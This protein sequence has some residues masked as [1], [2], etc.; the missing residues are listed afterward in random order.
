MPRELN[1][2]LND[3]LDAIRKIDKYTKHLSFNDFLENE[4]VQDGVVRNL[5][6]V[7][8]AVKKIPENMRKSGSQIDWK[9]VAGLRDILIHEYFAV[10][11]EIIWDVVV[12]KVPELKKV[13]IILLE[14][15]KK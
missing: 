12:N 7:G 3:I 8:E 9:K 11:L 10:D 5:E 4:L 1:T 6:V 2:Y 15:L 13:A 14:E